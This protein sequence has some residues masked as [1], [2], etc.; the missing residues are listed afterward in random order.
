MRPLGML[1]AA[2][3]VLGACAAQEEPF[4][5]AEVNVSSDLST[6]GSPEAVAFWQNL[7]RDLETALASEFVGVIS[8]AGSV[9]NVDVDELT[10]ASVLS[11][12]LGAEDA[13][14]AGSVEVVNPD[15]TTASAYRV[16]A[17]TQDVVTYLPPGTDVVSVQPTS[18][19]FYSAVIQAFARGTAEVV[20]QGA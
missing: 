17:T 19:A 12:G 1:A 2:A 20:M 18:A 14:L 9:V 7:D 4:T 13:R 8:P 3:L 5:V 16:T 11:S 10:L 15:G 6:I